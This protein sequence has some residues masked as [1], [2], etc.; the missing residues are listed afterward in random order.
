M[1]STPSAPLSPATKQR[2]F[3]TR[4]LSTVILWALILSAYAWRSEVLFALIPAAFGFATCLEFYRLVLGGDGARAH[5][6]LGIAVAI[7]YLSIGVWYALRQHSAQPMSY[8]IA[9]LVLTLQVAF[10]LAYRQP[11]D[12]HNTLWRVF[13]TVFGVL[14]TVV[15]YGFLTRLLHHGDAPLQGRYL[16]LYLIIVTKFTD[17]GAYLLGSLIGKHKMIPHISPAKS[18]EGFA[19]AF[20]GGFL[21]AS[22][23][24]WLVPNDLFPLTWTT[25]LACVPL[26][27]LVAVSGDLAE[28]VIKRCTAIKDSGHTLP[29][30]G[31]ILDLT[32]SLLFTAPVF[33]AYLCWL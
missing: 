4:L 16:M 18:W 15:C 9:A 11:L 30:I 27:T 23:M 24:L 5:H 3:F 1:A 17:M 28:S 29:G 20:I 22:I 8:D 25:G 19:G 31:G 32:D 13:A 14:Y 7:I 26:L 2:I 12:G 6:R 21:A 10:A 33:Y